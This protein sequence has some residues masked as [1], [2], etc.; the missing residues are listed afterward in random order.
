MAMAHC[1]RLHCTVR[2]ASMLGMALIVVAAAS[3][4]SWIGDSLELQVADA[5][6]VVRA[7]LETSKP[8]PGVSEHS[9]VLQI[10]ETLKGGVGKTIECLIPYYDGE[11]YLGKWEK[12]KTELLVCLVKRERHRNS[13]RRDAALPEYLVRASPNGQPNMIALDGSAD[14]RAP[15]MDFRFIT[16]SDEITK[17]AAAAM[18]AD[19]ETKVARKADGGCPSVVVNVPFQSPMDVEL[20]SKASNGLY[21]PLNELTE[22]HARKWITA[23]DA[24]LRRDGVSVLSHFKSDANIAALKAL[25]S[26]PEVQWRVEGANTIGRYPIRSAALDAL[27]AWGI[28]ATAIVSTTAPSKDP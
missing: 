13:L 1:R 23:S 28:D 4:Q 24:Q 27:K 16:K 9:G 19:K 18:R 7:T 17:L 8:I 15:T 6:V 20:H 5:D 22:A 2:I 3:A 11:R 14:R 25:F 26:D 21:L 10:K 12:D